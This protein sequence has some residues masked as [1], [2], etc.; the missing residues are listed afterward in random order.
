[1]QFTDR[2][3]KLP[4]RLY[5][6]KMKDLTGVE[7]SQDCEVRVNPFEIC[8]YHQTSDESGVPGILVYLKCGETFMVY[9]SL[10]DFEKRLNQHYEN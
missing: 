1:M 9:L 4:I 7:D 2:F 8:E 5:S 6:E 3:I 10:E